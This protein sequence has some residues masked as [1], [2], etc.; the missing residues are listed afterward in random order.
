MKSDPWI[1]CSPD[2]VAWISLDKVGFPSSDPALTSFEIKNIVASSS[3]DRSLSHARGVVCKCVLGDILFLQTIPVNH[4]PQLIK[5]ALV[6]EKDYVVYVFTSKIGIIFIFVVSVPHDVLLK[7]LSVIKSKAESLITW[8][9]INE[10]IPTEA[11]TYVSQ[12]SIERLPFWT[13]A[14]LIC[15]LQWPFPS[16]E[17]IKARL[18][19]FLLDN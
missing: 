10:S 1:A 12:T 19:I 3:M 2:G 5:Q 6:L 4:S 8:A 16:F 17:T 15:Q 9:H 7:C 11:E 14:K 13:A 18:C